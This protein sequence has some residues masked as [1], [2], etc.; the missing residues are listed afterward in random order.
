M[1]HRDPQSPEK[2]TRHARRALRYTAGACVAA[3]ALVLSACGGSEDGGPGQEAGGDLT[4]SVPNLPAKL[5]AD[6]AGGSQ[7]GVTLIALE[8]L[9]RYT[10]SGEVEPNLAESYEVVSPLEYVFTI[11]EG[12]KFWDGTEMTVDDVVESLSKHIGEDTTSSIASSFRDVKAVT[13]T[14]DNEVTVTMTKPNGRMLV[15]IARAGIFSAAFAE[16]AGEDLG[17]PETLNM[18]TG[19]YKFASFAPDS[20][21]GYERNENY[22]GEAP[23]HDEI[24]LRIVPGEQLTVGLQS[25]EFD[26]AF[27]VPLTLLDSLNAVDG[28]E[29]VQVPYPQVYAFSMSPD[30]GPW[31]DENVRQAFARIVNRDVIAEDVLAGARSALT[32]VDKELMTGYLPDDELDASYDEVAGLTPGFDVDEAKE[33]LAQSSYPDGFTSEVVVLKTDPALSLIAQTVAQDAAQIGI[34]LNVRELDETAYNEIVY[35]S[36]EKNEGGLALDGAEAG[37]PDPMD[38]ARL[39]LLST[40][41]KA[42]GAGYT[43]TAAVNDPDIDAAILDLLARP[44]DDP[45][46]IRLGLEALR[47]ESDIRAYVPIAFTTNNAY[48]RDSLSLGDYTSFWWMTNWADAITAS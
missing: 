22:W 43:N 48:Y 33:F 15:S 19:P 37:A 32:L 31:Q 35:F 23:T 36:P 42:G 4:I 39:K 44:L 24:E 6:A 9:L 13:A 27:V 46:R 14:G 30:K 2:S 21:V 3:L 38:L 7:L 26:A 17:S 11:R 25:Q 45:E 28:Y 18:G 29:S 47:L 8:P 12:V 5:A 10:P 34:T 41:T 1:E 16:E 20:S 40:L